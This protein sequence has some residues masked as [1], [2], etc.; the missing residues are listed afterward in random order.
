M[1]ARSDIP[2]Q[3]AEARQRIILVV[4]DEILVRSAIA[5]YLRDRGYIAIEAANAAEAVA[6]LLCGTT[7]DLILSDVEMPGGMNGLDLVQW[8][9]ERHPALPIV[10]TS[11]NSEMAMPA[12]LREGSLFL[13]KP[14]RLDELILHL[15]ALLATK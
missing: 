12:A 3:P 10:L 5:E 7:P 9:R 4:E 15:A 2:P 14:Y 6:L 1:I 11:G 8:V 13:M